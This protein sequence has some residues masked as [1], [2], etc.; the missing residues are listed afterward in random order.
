MGRAAAIAFILFV[1]ILVFTGL[2]RLALRRNE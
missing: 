1:V 2:Q